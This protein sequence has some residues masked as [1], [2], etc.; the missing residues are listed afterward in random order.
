MKKQQHLTGMQYRTDEVISAVEDFF[1]D[2]DESY[3]LYHGNPS[4]SCT[5]MHGRSTIMCANAVLNNIAQK[6]VVLAHAWSIV[7]ANSVIIKVRPYAKYS[8]EKNSLK[9]IKFRVVKLFA[10]VYFYFWVCQDPPP[11]I[12]HDV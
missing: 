11:P 4:A 9:N 7:G 10:S 3:N 12:H 5:P 6:L 2:Q 8:Y 1:E